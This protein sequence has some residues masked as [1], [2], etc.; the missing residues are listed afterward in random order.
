MNTANPETQPT[1]IDGIVAI[2]DDDPH[3][4]R[5]LGMWLEMYGLRAAHHTSGEGLLHAICQDDGHLTLHIGVSHSVA[6]PMVGAVLDLNLPG[7][8]G[9]Q[10][11]QA[12]RRLAPN[13]PMAI[14]TAL[15]EDDRKRFGHLPT[16]VLCLKKPFDL[17]ALEDALFP[18]L[19]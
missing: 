3:I 17:G 5:A 19:N 6:F 4:S 11:A 7:I 8:T 13:L 9:I 10:L 12:L 14:I 1:P 16:G 18:L 2:V 15:H